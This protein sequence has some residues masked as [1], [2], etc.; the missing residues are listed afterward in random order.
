MMPDTLFDREIQDPEMARLFAQ[1]DLIEEAGELIAR[2]MKERNLTK[3]G[4]ARRIGVTK[5]YVTQLLAGS[6]NMTLRTFA[7]LMYAMEEKVLLTSTSLPAED[8]AG[9]MCWAISIPRR[10]PQMEWGDVELV[11]CSGGAAA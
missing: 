7:D 10:S 3:S 4:L 1:E 6:R 9:T 11:P 2:T 8:P 5:G